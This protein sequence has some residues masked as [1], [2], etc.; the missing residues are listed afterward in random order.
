VEIGTPLPDRLRRLL[1]SGRDVVLPHPQPLRPQERSRII[2][3]WHGDQF[4]F[5][6][7]DVADCRQWMNNRYGPDRSGRSNTRRRD[8]VGESP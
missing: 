2:A 7:D 3:A 6:A 5:L 8:L 1:E 4:Y